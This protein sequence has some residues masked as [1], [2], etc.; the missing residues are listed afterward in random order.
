METVIYVKDTGQVV[1]RVDR[2]SRVLEE[3]ENLCQSEL[4]GVP[5][6]YASV[7]APKRGPG[8]I[9]EIQSGAAVL[10]PDPKSVARDTAKASAYTKL[11]AIG[12]TAAEIA[13]LYGRE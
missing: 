12:L 6:D 5:S 9:W 11:T 10:I 4:R 7:E 3:I 2:Q 8:Q 13:V 1:G